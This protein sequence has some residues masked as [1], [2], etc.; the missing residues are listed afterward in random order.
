MLVRLRSVD[1][2]VQT[3]ICAG[4]VFSS[5]PSSL[6]D[7]VQYRVSLVKEMSAAVTRVVQKWPLLAGKGVWLKEENILGIDVPSPDALPDKLFTLTQATV[8]SPYPVSEPL[9]ARPS[10]FQGIPTRN[11][12]QDLNVP[13]TLLGLAKK[14]MP[15]LALRFTFFTDA[16]AFGITMPHQIFDGTGA[17][18]VVQAMNAELWNEP[19]TPP[20]VYEQNPMAAAIAALPPPH[21][22]ELPADYE[23]VL[24]PGGPAGIFKV[25]LRCLWEKYAWQGG[26]ETYLFLRR[27]AVERLVRKVKEEVRAMTGGK[28]YVSTS[29][30]LTAWIYKTTDSHK[31]SSS[32]TQEAQGVF[33]SRKV[34]S[35]PDRDLEA[36]PFNAILPYYLFD[37]PVA[38]SEYPF[39]SLA[40]LA[41]RHRRSVIRF[42]TKPV[43]AA[44]ERD[45]VSVPRIPRREL[46]LP[47][48]LSM[49]RFN[50]QAAT[51]ETSSR[52]LWNNLDCDFANLRLPDLAQHA[53]SKGWRPLP[54]VMFHFFVLIPF[55]P[56]HSLVM[57]QLD[58]GYIIFGSMRPEVRKAFEAAAEKLDQDQ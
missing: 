36:Y 42:R 40:E 58:E 5:P 4:W 55:T 26:E 52:C 53:D 57:H 18:V 56:D 44:L 17:A 3:Q 25:L 20:P 50:G 43:V 33:A 15:L 24:A 37:P 39:I 28:E 54:L 11:H 7:A 30:V 14:G 47:W 49:S 23:T 1:T 9:S 48:P 19:W 45:V 22:G 51:R 6:A 21:P 10:G 16:V 29:D 38:F 46:P 34:L 8:D 13:L 32:A 2:T 27:A 31:G 41:L 12:F 35:T